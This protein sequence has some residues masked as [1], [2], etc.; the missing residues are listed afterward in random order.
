MTKILSAI[1]TLNHFQGLADRWRVDLMDQDTHEEKSIFGTDF[2]EALARI[3]RLVEAVKLWRKAGPD[4]AVFVTNEMDAALA[5]VL[6]EE[7]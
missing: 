3:E 5:A 7:G 2:S 6:G 4:D 1:E